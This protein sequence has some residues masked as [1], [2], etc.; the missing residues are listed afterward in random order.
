MVACHECDALNRVALQGAGRCLCH[1]CSA[2]LHCYDELELTKSLAFLLAGLVVFLIANIF[3]VVGLEIGGMHLATN[4]IET[5]YRLQQQGMWMVGLL[6]FFTGFLLPAIELL[7]MLYLL[8][9]LC[10]G[11]APS[12][13]PQVMR[14]VQLVHPWGMVEVFLLGVLVSLVKLAHMA[15]VHPGVGLWA[16]FVLIVLFALNV[17]RFDSVSLWECYERCQNKSH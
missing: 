6:V 10:L 9:P 17:S 4:L 8:L 14:M 2:E 7:G 1:R 3:P 15:S 16:F 13:F 11:R 5:A 12:A